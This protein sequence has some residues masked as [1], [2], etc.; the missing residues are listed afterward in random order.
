MPETQH[1]WS[2]IL[3]PVKGELAKTRAVELLKQTFSISEEEASQVVG[4]APVILLENLNYEVAQK[5]RYYFHENGQE[6]ILSNN[7]LHKRKCFKTVWPEEPRLNFIK[8]EPFV[9]DVPVTSSK[10]EPLS[11]EQ[12]VTHIREEIERNGQVHIKTVGVEENDDSKKRHEILSHQYELLVEERLIQ[13]QK[14]EALEREVRFLKDKESSTASSLKSVASDRENLLHE[15]EALR[16]K[17]ELA[18]QQFEER[19]KPQERKIALL[20]AEAKSMREKLDSL[21]REYEVAEKMWSGKLAAREQEC[22]RFQE[23]IAS[24]R[25]RMSEISAQSDQEKARFEKALAQE[26]VGFY[27]KALKDLVRKQADLEKEI[28]DKEKQLKATLSEQEALEKEIVRA[29]QKNQE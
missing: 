1:G 12:A 19:E 28:T 20:E 21:G 2:I 18:V 10:R 27:E 11:T 17:H 8:S 14:I 22:V 4:N 6:I 3:N 5:V 29:K 25:L 23:E 13:E 9:F 24:V 7:P 26:K 15:F 16:L